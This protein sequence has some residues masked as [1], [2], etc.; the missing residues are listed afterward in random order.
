LPA[1]V[2][3]LCFTL[4]EAKQYRIS[5]FT[6]EGSGS[7]LH[8]SRTEYDSFM[9]AVHNSRDV[10]GLLPFS[11]VRGEKLCQQEGLLS[12]LSSV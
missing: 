2:I 10:P 6:S 11:C 5:C 3:M 4:Q 7:H 8:S 12:K 1:T 9:R